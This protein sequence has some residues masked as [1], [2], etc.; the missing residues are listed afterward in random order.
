MRYI[1]VFVFG[2]L[3][4]S[5]CAFRSLSDTVESIYTDEVVIKPSKVNYGSAPNSSK[6]AIVKEEI[7]QKSS[8]EIA[9]AQS[10]KFSKKGYIRS[11]SFDSDVKLYIYNFATIDNQEL[12][13]FYDK[14]L[15]YSYSDLIKVDVKDN[16]LV[17]AKALKKDASSKELTPSQ[18]RKLIIKRRKRS[19]IHEAVEEKIN[20]L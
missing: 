10:E 1:T 14:K 5:S 4:L 12:V 8:D 2:V 11:F 20:T 6:R 13:F 17:S 7:I 15:P 16:F 3:F 18:K 19:N 9:K